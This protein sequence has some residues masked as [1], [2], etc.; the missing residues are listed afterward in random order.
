[1]IKLNGRTIVLQFSVFLTQWLLMIIGFYLLAMV[2]APL[3][4]VD[5]AFAFERYLDSALKGVIG[6]LMSVSWLYLWDRQ[7]RVFFYRKNR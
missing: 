7:V 1:M 4:V 2:I 3:R 6:V 5:T